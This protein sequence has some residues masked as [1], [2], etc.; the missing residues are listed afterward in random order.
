MAPSTFQES[1]IQQ[2]CITEMDVTYKRIYRGHMKEFQISRSSKNHPAQTEMEAVLA[3]NDKLLGGKRPLVFDG[4]AADKP[5]PKRQHQSDDFEEAILRL[6]TQRLGEYHQPIY[7]SPHSKPSLQASDDDV[8]PLMDHITQFLE[9]E[10]KAMLILGDSGAGK[11]TFN[12][13]LE[14]QLWT[15]YETSGSIPLFINLPAIHKPEQDM[16]AKQMQMYGFMD[17]QIQKIKQSCRLTIICDG[18]DEGRLPGNLYV[19]NLLNRPQ[20][21]RAKLLISCRSQSL[22][23]DYVSQFAPQS[24]DHYSTATDD[25]F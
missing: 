12:R 4:D 24:A 9:S 18:Y 22:G 8:M 1:N 17:D 21:W 3:E 16:V 10:G 2:G 14:H 7:V 6:R 5:I 23:H 13:H 11:S 19:T 15:N 20:Q 25:A